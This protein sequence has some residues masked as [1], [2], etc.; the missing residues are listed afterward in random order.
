MARATPAPVWPDGSVPVALGISGALGIDGRTALELARQARAAGVAAVLATEVSSVDAVALSA[1]L[2]AVAPDVVTGTGVVPLGTR[3]VPAL[4][5]G[6]WTAATVS[7]VPYL[8]GVGV[9]TRQIVGGW[10]GA[11]YDPS[12]STT[13]ARLR[14]LRE[15]LGKTRRGSF[16]LP[17]AGQ[18]DVRVLLGA[19]GPRMVELGLTEADGV[20]VNHTPPAHL[21]GPVP[22]RTVMAYCWVLAAP[23]GD[24]RARRDVVSYM[25]AEPYARHFAR[26][27]FGEVVAEARALHAAGRLREAPARLPDELVHALFVTPE[28]LPRRLAELR[29][30]GA[31]PVLMPVT[32]A[33]PAEEMSELL[34]RL[35]AMSLR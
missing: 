24:L 4:A 17:A 25:M 15:V 19:M 13:R 3:S 34:T 28:G 32:G 7:A 27:G 1:A 22:G 6:A 21:P 23:D 14:E 30:A 33:R 26:L 2:A 11:A 8:L 5:M 10:H 16:A 29:A 9:S 12:V 18:A 35:P 31:V 20:I